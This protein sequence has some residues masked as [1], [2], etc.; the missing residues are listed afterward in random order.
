M[1]VV[2]RSRGGKVS[3]VEKER[4]EARMTRVARLNGRLDRFDVEVITEATPRVDGG[5]RVEAAARGGRQ[6]FRAV[7]T[8]P[9]LEVALEKAAEK[10]E[11]Q[12]SDAHG[13]RRARLL[14][15]ANRIKS[16]MHAPPE[17]EA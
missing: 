7:G 16:G 1:D 10:L 4:I 12:V 2:V 9:E 15:G 5:H 13:R 11:R 3:P 17:L 14:G 6:M 8:G